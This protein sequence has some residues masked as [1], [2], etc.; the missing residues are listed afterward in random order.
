MAKVYKLTFYA[1]DPCDY[2]DDAQHLFSQLVS[3]G[4]RTNSMFFRADEADLK[5]SI[6]F[7]W[8]DSCKLNYSNAQKEDFEHYLTEK[9]LKNL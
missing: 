4:T 9:D 1:V 2:Y 7:P 8:K 3:M 5:T 6:E